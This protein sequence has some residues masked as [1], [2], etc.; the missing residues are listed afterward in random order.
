MIRVT[1]QD[2]GWYHQKKSNTFSMDEVFAMIDLVVDNSLDSATE[3]TGS[4]SELP[5]ALTQLLRWLTFTYITMNRPTWK[6]LPRRIME[7]PNNSTMP[8]NSSMISPL[9]ITMDT[10]TNAKMGS[11]QKS[12]SLIRRTKKITGQHS[13]TLK[14]TLTMENSTLRPMTNRKH[15]IL[16]LSIILISLGTYLNDQSMAY[17][18]PKLYIMTRY[19]TKPRILPPN[20]TTHQ[21]TVQETLLQRTAAGSLEEMLQEEPL[22]YGKTM[23]WDEQPFGQWLLGSWYMELVPWFKP[24]NQCVSSWLKTSHHQYKSTSHKA[25]SQPSSQDK[26]IF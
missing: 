24:R 2:A 8:A 5:W 17:T 12:W 20:Q 19:V 15:L 22:D 13:S 23:P 18:S 4:A 7:S 6:L 25:P 3:S 1:Q 9:S 16:I 11:S 10:C 21:Q 14:S 26:G